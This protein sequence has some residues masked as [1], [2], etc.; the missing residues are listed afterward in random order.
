MFHV[1]L[2]R[3]RIYLSCG[4]LK[5]KK[6]KKN[7]QKV[8]RLTKAAKKLTFLFKTCFSDKP[9]LVYKRI[10]YFS[11]CHRQYFKEDVDLIVTEDSADHF[12]TYETIEGSKQVIINNLFLS[13]F[14]NTRDTTSKLMSSK[15][16]AQL[17]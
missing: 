5:K 10:I 17:N 14:L 6:K 4:G 3:A 7:R 15:V 16:Y 2:S 12:A 13:K 1:L 8:A 11:R 9:L